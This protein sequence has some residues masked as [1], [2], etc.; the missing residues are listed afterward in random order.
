MTIALIEQFIDAFQCFSQV[1]DFI[2]IGV[3]HVRGLSVF[4]I[5]KFIRKLLKII[6]IRLDNGNASCYGVSRSDVKAFPEDGYEQP[7]ATDMIGGLNLCR[8]SKSMRSVQSL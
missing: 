6:L 2:G 4:S 8:N 5:S 7:H 3:K 1:G